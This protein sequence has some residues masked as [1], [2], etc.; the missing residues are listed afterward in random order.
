MLSC[1]SPVAGIIW[2]KDSTLKIWLNVLV[3]F[4]TN[5]ISPT[6]RIDHHIYQK[7]PM[8]TQ[9][10]VAVIANKYD[11][12]DVSTMSWMSIT[13]SSI[14]VEPKKVRSETRI[15]GFVVTPIDDGSC[16][17]TLAVES[18]LKGSFDSAMM[19]SMFNCMGVT[20]TAATNFCRDCN[21]ALGRIK[22]MAES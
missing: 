18:A 8:L 4:T 22:V 2:D 6:S 14:P 9:R 1:V 19:R 20:K 21:A 15:L 3:D 11:E 17:V 10:D 16:S 12:G 13:T 7:Q 5:E